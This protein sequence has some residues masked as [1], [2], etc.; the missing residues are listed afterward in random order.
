MEMDFPKL[1]C[2]TSNPHLCTLV[3]GVV[4]GKLFVTKFGEDKKH[5]IPRTI[6]APKIYLISNR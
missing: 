1:Y 4:L 3:N 5:E 6:F 2:K